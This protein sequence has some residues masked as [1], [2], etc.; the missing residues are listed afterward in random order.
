MQRAGFEISRDGTMRV[1]TG[2]SVATGFV[3]DNATPDRSEWN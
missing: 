2:K 3:N 1:I